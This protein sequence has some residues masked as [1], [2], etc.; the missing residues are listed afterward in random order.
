MRKY[1]L[2][3]LIMIFILIGCTKSLIGANRFWVATTTA[4]WSSSS[5]S[6]TSNGSPGAS[7]PTTTDTAVFDGGNGTKIGN[8][9]IPATV[10][11]AGIKVIS[12]YSGTISQNAPLTV[13]V[14]AIFSAGTFTSSGTTITCNT[15]CSFTL[16]GCT[17]T[18]SSAN[19]SLGGTVTYSSGTFNNNSGTVTFASGS[20]QTVPAWNYYNLTFSGSGTRAFASGTIGIANVFT[21]GTNTITAPTAGMISY[22]GSGAQ[23]ISDIKYFNLDIVARSEN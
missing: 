7:V 13:S 16:S 9:T 5:W 22:N 12:L 19:L 23:S 1:E 21:R 6:T 17:F 4:N 3:R 11:V 20:T 8:C 2:I 18:S 15:G 10:T 14:V